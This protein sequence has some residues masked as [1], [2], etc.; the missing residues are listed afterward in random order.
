MRRPLLALAALSLPLSCSTASVVNTTFNFDRATDVDFVCLRVEAGVVTPLRIT[1]CGLNASDNTSTTGSAHLYAVVT[2]SERGELAVV[3]LAAASGT[4][5]IDNSPD[6]PGFSF[7]PIGALPTALVSD[8][9]AAGTPSS[10]WIASTGSRAIERLD[11][12]TILYNPRRA[13][14]AGREVV[15]GAPLAL[16]GAPRDLA[17]DTVGGRTLLYATVPDRAAVAVFDVTDPLHPADMGFTPITAPAG[18]DGGLDASTGNAPAHP[19]A[20]AV[21]A[22]THR[23]YVSD[24]RSNFVHVLEAM[25]LREQS[26]IDVGA[27]TRAL[28]VSGW[29]RATLS[30]AAADADPDHFAR[31]RYLYAANATTGA[32][33]VYDLTRDARV[34]PNVLPAPNPQR[35][36][37]DPSLADDRVALA[38]PAVALVPINTAEYR[39]P[40]ASGEITVPPACDTL[41]G[42]A[43]AAATGPGYLH[44]VF[45]GAVLRDGS[46]AVIDVDDYDA[47]A[48]S[49][50]CNVI[51]NANAYRFVRHAPRAS[52]A[53]TDAPLVASAPVHS[54]LVRGTQRVQLAEAPTT[55][56][57]G[58]TRDRT[59]GEATSCVAAPDGGVVANYGIELAPRAPVDP[60]FIPPPEAGDGGPACVTPDA[61]PDAGVDASLPADPY[62]LRN[63]L[64]GLTY[65][66]VL[67]GLDLYG[68]A[69]VDP[70]SPGDG[71]GGRVAAACV[72]A[73]GPNAVVL[74]APNA[75]FC[76]HGALADDAYARDQV[77][78]QGD[79]TPL[80][81]D[82]ALCARTF[83]TA[84][85]QANRDLVIEQARQECLVLRLPAGVT[86]D[87]LRR[88]FPL[89]AH[90]EVR[91]N[92][93]WVVQGS[94]NGYLT[95]VRADDRGRCALDD[96]RQSAVEALSRA[97]LTGRV[98]LATRTSARCLAGRACMG[99]LDA[100]GAVTLASTPVFANSFF[101]L[102][103]FPAV[104]SEGGRASI[105]EPSREAQFRFS[106]SGGWEPLVRNEAGIFP[107]SARHVPHTNRLYVVDTQSSGLIEFR[108]DPVARA[109]IFN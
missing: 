84:A 42:C 41:S 87:L 39:G 52:A 62:A 108:T 74:D 14:D 46:L 54:A 65:E 32:V 96:A 97:C 89:A 90:V 4:S 38:A 92:G 105:V 45:M 56:A 82:A 64:W 2:Q 5:L 95:A 70:A 88:C 71:D 102:Q 93:Q 22:E 53:L 100:A 73:A 26:R 63:E 49:G 36:L 57:L 109:R 13:S 78:V 80:A 60:A 1:D 6:L 103:V 37:I 20:L 17:I 83:G 69:F 18:A 47:R 35:R 48:R 91:A 29:A 31:A 104:S 86:A 66:G 58:C 40:D 67:P 51:D 3:D 12:S 44:G 59:A 76:T 10:I 106:I 72:D 7:I 24:D 77:T 23:V 8:V 16:N 30:R 50:A 21:D 85:Q 55:P 27:P 81:S 99:A 9:R 33:V 11:A 34:R 68:A 19:L 101:C 25:P 79:P 43:G 15:R 28:A 107:V 98:P 75:G 61:G 94:R